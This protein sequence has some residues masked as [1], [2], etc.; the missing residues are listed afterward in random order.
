MNVE[1]SHIA[2]VLGSM[3]MGGA[4]RAS[5]NL[6][7]EFA[8]RGVRCDLVLVNAEGELLAEV[9]PEV[10]KVPL[11][12]GR[13]LYSVFALRRYI[14]K[15]KPQVVIAGQTHVQLMTL[16]ARK[17]TLS[18]I[19]VILNEHSTFSTNNSGTTLKGR[20]IKRLAK[21]YFSRA[22]SIIAVSEGVKQDMLD[23]FPFLSPLIDVIYNPVV[24][25]SLYEKSNLKV[26]MPWEENHSI[27]V[28][29]AVGRL[30]QD[31]DY[32]NLIHA[33]AI[34]RNDR[35]VRLMIIG[36]GPEKE[37]FMQLSEQLKF[38]EDINF[39]GTTNNPYALMKQADIFVL[40]SKREG[41]PMSLIEAL[42][43]GCRVVSTD[44]VSG[45]SE[46]LKGGKYGRLVPVGDKSALVSA[47]LCSLDEKT[48]HHLN[49]EAIQPFLV[50]TVCDKYSRLILSLMKG[51]LCNE[52]N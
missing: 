7:N 1:I 12:K 4:E 5:L 20:L 51:R 37:S 45:P 14:K 31:K 9:N 10:N 47:L 52:K 17:R 21:H 44:C 33:V 48:D 49:D 26:Q 39:Y 3:R 27:P 50:K 22:D 2:L 25:N 40:S 43:C 8:A 46:I 18:H 38:D 19:P 34:V 15:I 11:A 36:D 28:I 23:Q 42:A 29:L 30:V 13:T 24:G 32:Q 16:M 35:R 41:L 6:V